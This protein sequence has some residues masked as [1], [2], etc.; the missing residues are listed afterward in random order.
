[1]P[2]RKFKK[3]CQTSLK[4]FFNIQK[5]IRKCKILGFQLPP[6]CFK[7]IFSKSMVSQKDYLNTNIY[8]YCTVLHISK[9]IYYLHCLPLGQPMHNCHQMCHKFPYHLRI[10]LIKIWKYAFSTDYIKWSEVKYLC[11]GCHVSFSGKR[12]WKLFG[13]WPHGDGSHWPHF[14]RC[15]D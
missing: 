7:P 14:F 5:I 9:L 6:D 8:I 11:E 12:K 1:M 13:K 10:S 3:T 4:N 2:A 15:G